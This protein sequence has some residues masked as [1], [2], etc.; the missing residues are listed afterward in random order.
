LRYGRD[1]DGNVVGNGDDVC[2]NRENR[3]YARIRNL[4]D[5]KAENLTVHFDRTNPLGVGIRDS[6]GWTPIGSVDFS[7]FPEL[8]EIAPGG[9]AIVYTEWSPSVTPPPEIAG[10]GRFPFHS[11]VRVRVDPVTDERITAN[12]DGDREQENIGWFEAVLDTGRAT[13]SLIERELNLTNTDN[14]PRWFYLHAYSELPPGWTL[15]VAGGERNFYLEPNETRGIPIQIQA[16]PD[17]PVG[18]S[19]F[20]KVDAFK[21][22]AKTDTGGRIIRYHSDL[23]GGVLVA[24]QTVVESSMTLTAAVDPPDSCLPKS[25]IVNGCLSDAVDGAVVA[26]DY[27]AP[28]GM[29][30]TELAT[31][32]ATGCFEA[33]LSGTLPGGQWTVSAFWHGDLS[34]ASVE[35]DPLTVAASDPAD[36]DC[37]DISNG[38]DNCPEVH[39]PQQ[40]D[41]D[42]DGA[43]DACDC[44]TQDP[45]SWSIPD[46]ITNLRFTDKI[47]LGWDSVVPGAGPSTVHELLRGALSDLGSGGGQ[48]VNDCFVSDVEGD[49]TTD[50]ELPPPTAAF[51]YLVRGTNPCGDGSVGSG[52]NG[53]ARTGGTCP[54]CSH[55]RCV[56]GGPLDA[57]CDDCVRSICDVQPSC[58]S[59]G[60][61]PSCVEAV[62]TVCG[63]LVCGESQGQCQHTLCST[64][65]LL[66]PFCDSPPAP[67]SCVDQICNADP[68]CCQDSWDAVCVGEVESV[69]GNNCD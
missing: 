4:G 61:D 43:G 10:A 37:D 64:G 3:L 22:E 16:P 5:V 66:Q 23:V 42:N 50:A 62:R 48:Q 52:S 2:A 46:A 55:D 59:N 14:I 38:S 27:T 60:W 18:Q 41:T 12:Q 6:D 36:L 31:T 35:S 49:S 44:A 34:H 1:V 25:I 13:Y 67:N 39:N 11:C 24:A 9:E 32:D 63:S 47:T 19:Y 26:V 53:T 57:T 21:S 68:F 7:L 65:D 20:V 15:D 51:W 69:C 33:T 8:V 45:T 40:L 56:E 17:A 58:C 29:M 30:T 28:A 54:Q